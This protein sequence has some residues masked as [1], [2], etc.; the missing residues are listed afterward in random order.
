MFASSASLYRPEARRRNAAV[1]DLPQVSLTPY[2]AGTG[3]PVI[4]NIAFGASL[5]ARLGVA[6]LAKGAAIGCGWR[7]DSGH[8]RSP[9]GV[10]IQ[11]P[12]Q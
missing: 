12:E 11:L 10:T 2:R 8:Q 7:L 1:A 4:N 3:W 9:E 6:P 5:M